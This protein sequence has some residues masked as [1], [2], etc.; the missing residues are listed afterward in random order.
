MSPEGKE[1]LGAG[2]LREQ[3]NQGVPIPAEFHSDH[4][5][6]LD[7]GDQEETESGKGSIWSL[8]SQLTAPTWSP[9]QSPLF[10]S[11]H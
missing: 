11:N 4:T 9:H 8:G 2:E 3:P 10:L 1:T 5:D 6:K 7:L